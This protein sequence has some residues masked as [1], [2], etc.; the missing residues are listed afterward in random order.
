MGSR[1]RIDSLLV[2]SR[3]A[4]DLAMARRAIR[5]KRVMACVASYAVKQCRVIRNVHQPIDCH[6]FIVM[7]GQGGA[8]SAYCLAGRWVL[9]SG[10]L[11]FQGARRRRR[12]R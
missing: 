1:L 10:G 2:K 3:L 8:D 4:S 11:P 6:E 12:G 9:R 7:Q 5:S